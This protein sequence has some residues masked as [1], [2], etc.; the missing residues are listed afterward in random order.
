[1][2]YQVLQH[3]SFETCGI[4]AD[5]IRKGGHRLLTTA[6]YDGQVLPALEDF[7]ALIVMGGPMSI[8]DESEFP[9]LR[10]E[11]E[12]IAAAIRQRKKVLGICLGAQLIAA[13]CGAKVYPNPQKEIGYWPIRW[14]E[15]SGEAKG[16]DQ[17]TA[18]TFRTPGETSPPTQTFFHWHG[19]TFDLPEGAVL[20]ASTDACTNQAFRL[21]NHVLGV[22]FH[23]EVTPE[24]IDGMI[25]HEGWEL[26][27]APF[28]QTAG[29][30]LSRTAALA[31]PSRPDN[32]VNP[33]ISFLTNWL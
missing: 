20:L 9:W 26:V 12:L 27:D 33:A 17:P 24:I 22:Q 15:K 16:P 28:V 3:V 32:P 4:L 30:I 29:E 25:A 18:G 21:G 6:L 10:A 1:M 7:D 5:F 23:P 19:E 13:A 2:R 8:H 14:V 11:K 31:Q